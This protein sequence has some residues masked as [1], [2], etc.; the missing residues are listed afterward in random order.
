MGMNPADFR[1]LERNKENA[2]NPK[3]SKP[4]K[5]KKDICTFCKFEIEEATV[6]SLSV[7]GKFHNRCITLAKIRGELNAKSKHKGQY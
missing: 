2:L 4:R 1:Q 6:T 5:A 3:K 7:E